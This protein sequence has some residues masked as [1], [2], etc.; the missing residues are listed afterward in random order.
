M[1]RKETKVILVILELFSKRF[2]NI[3]ILFNL[4]YIN[5]EHFVYN[6]FSVSN[7]WAIFAKDKIKSPT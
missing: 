3:L 2:D 7:S 4:V 6:E 5:R 1:L